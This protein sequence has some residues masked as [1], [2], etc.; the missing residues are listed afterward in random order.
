[1]PTAHVQSIMEEVIFEQR[2]E[3]NLLHI[4]REM[5][6]QAEKKVCAETETWELCVGK[7]HISADGWR[8]GKSVNVRK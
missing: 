5:T 7:S 2:L 4:S 8:V 3:G 6:F 1:M